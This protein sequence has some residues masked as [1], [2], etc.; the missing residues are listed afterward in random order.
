[1]IRPP[2]WPR[3]VFESTDL[4][5]VL[6]KHSI[7]PFLW[8]CSFEV[9]P[10]TAQ[11]LM[12]AGTTTLDGASYGYDPVGK[13][14]SKVNKLSNITEGYSYGPIHELT[15]VAVIHARADFTSVRE[16]SCPLNKSGSPLD[17]ASA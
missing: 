6:I 17:F 2:R 11:Y 16:K 12:R 7:I 5:S 10:S 8:V 15:Q 9:K 4:H 13:R 14:T 3:E 1:M